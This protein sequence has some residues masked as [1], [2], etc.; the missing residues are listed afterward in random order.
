ME[1]MEVT[2]VEVVVSVVAAA[3]GIHRPVCPAL[4][5]VPPQAPFVR[6]AARSQQCRTP[7]PLSDSSWR[8]QPT[9]WATTHWLV[10]LHLLLPSPPRS[11]AAGCPPQR[12]QSSTQRPKLLPSLQARCL[13]LRTGSGKTGLPG[14]PGPAACHSPVGR[15]RLQPRA[16]RGRHAPAPSLERRLCEASNVPP[17]GNLR[18]RV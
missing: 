9:M 16:A 14:A 11:P 4:G 10:P 3:G 13:A 5:P 1:V 2:L 6:A 15:P 12:L 17:N 18:R 8:S 7:S